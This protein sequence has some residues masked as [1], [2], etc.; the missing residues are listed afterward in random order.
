MS[1]KR[2]KEIETLT[3]KLY[4][5]YTTTQIKA[6]RYIFAYTQIRVICNLGGDVPAWGYE[7]QDLATS[8]YDKY[9]KDKVA[10]EYFATKIGI[11]EN[12]IPRCDYHDGKYH[13]I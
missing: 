8:I 12:T 13:N 5:E 1:P 6:L 3:A 7:I 11:D 2:Q 9:K 4:A 10:I